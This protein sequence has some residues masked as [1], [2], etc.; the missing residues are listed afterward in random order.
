MWRSRFG[1]SR[2]DLP[3]TPWEIELIHRLPN[4]NAS[5]VRDRTES[6]EPNVDV[7]HTAPFTTFFLLLFGGGFYHIVN[8]GEDVQGGKTGALLSS[9]GIR[10]T[11]R[12]VKRYVILVFTEQGSYHRNMGC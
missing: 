6:E 1:G 7:L 2:A 11:R 4:D 3:K 12:S 10:H 8:G 5:C 9:R